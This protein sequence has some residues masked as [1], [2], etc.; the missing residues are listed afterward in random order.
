MPGDNNSVSAENN[1]ALTKNKQTTWRPYLATARTETT[2]LIDP[3]GNFHDNVT[4]VQELIQM[5]ISP[6]FPYLYRLFH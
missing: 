6:W 1:A 3:Q 2:F 5:S 4:A